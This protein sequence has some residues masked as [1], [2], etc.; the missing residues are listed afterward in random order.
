[1]TR[2][3]SLQ[4]TAGGQKPPAWITPSLYFLLP[5]PCGNALFRALWAQKS[6]LLSRQTCHCLPPALKPSAVQAAQFLRRLFYVSFLIMAKEAAVR[7]KTEKQLFNAIKKNR[8]C[9]LWTP[10]VFVS[11]ANYFFFLKGLDSG[12]FG[13]SAARSVASAA[14]RSRAGGLYR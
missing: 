6:L 9:P 13:W 10:S 3:G 11:I 14:A 1:M 8:R 7:Q 2:S 5:A 12:F 4:Y